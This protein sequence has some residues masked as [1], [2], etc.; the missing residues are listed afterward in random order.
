[1]KIEKNKIVFASIVMVVVIFLV[2]YSTLVLL[3]GE[4]ELENLEQISVPELK[5]EIEP[6]TSKI[7]ALDDLKEERERVV[8]SI[9]SEE[10]LDS[11]GV[12]D[13][14]L[15]E[16]EKEWAVDSLYNYG[17][18]DYEEG[19]YREE[20]YE[21]GNPEVEEIPEPTQNPANDFQEQHILFF[22]TS[23][24]EAP[25]KE[26]MSTDEELGFLAEVNGDQQVRVNDRLELILTEDMVLGERKFLKNTLV[27]GFVSFQPNRVLLK[28][29]HIN[30]YPVQLKA[31]DLQDGNEGIYIENSFRSEAQRE[32]MDDVVQDLNIAGLPQISG[33][34][35]IFRRN[36]KTIKVNILDQYK[37]ILKP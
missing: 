14:F 22:R 36:N 34:K 27:Y 33:I 2:A 29:T 13:P 24:V 21:E 15:E 8:P 4:E 32:V 11:L 28:V 10:L 30:N 3:G 35:N 12:Y 26:E 20:N 25:A 6:Y 7:D 19:D 37:L 5:E 31:Y 1:M 18:I 17:M 9:Y 23:P 16:K